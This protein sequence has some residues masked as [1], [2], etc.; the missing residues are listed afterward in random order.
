MCKLQGLGLLNRKLQAAKAGVL[1]IKS[2]PSKP[3]P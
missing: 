2:V 1:K 3:I